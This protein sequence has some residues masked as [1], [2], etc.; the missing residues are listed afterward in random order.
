MPNF[1]GEA[2]MMKT[3][4]FYP[5]RLNDPI[6]KNDHIRVNPNKSVARNR[7]PAGIQ[8]AVNVT[9]QNLSHVYSRLVFWLGVEMIY[10]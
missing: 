4:R 9:E 7:S 2:A 10:Y 8:N 6:E 1:R 3:G 5:R